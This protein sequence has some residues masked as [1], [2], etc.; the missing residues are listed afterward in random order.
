MNQI[1]GAVLGLAMALFYFWIFCLVLN[2]FVS[3][4][5]GQYLIN[6]IEATPWLAFLYR[7]NLLSGILLSVIWNLL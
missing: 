7:N 5:W 6:T 3:T 4:D 1:A 2:L